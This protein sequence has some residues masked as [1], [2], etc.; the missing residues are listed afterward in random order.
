MIILP[1][2]VIKFLEK[3]RKN[4]F[5]IYIVGGAVRNLLLNKGVTNWD[6]TTDATPEQILKLFKDAF[7]NNTYGT[8]SIPVGD[9]IFEVTPFR[10]EG[11]YKDF[12]H[13]EKI[14]WAKTVEEDLSRRDF[15]I[16]AM[17]YDGKKIVDPYK[18]Q[19]DLKNKL[20]KAVGDPDKRFNED[21]LRLI[22][23][24]RFASQLG[25]FIDEKT[26][27]SIEKNSELIT[28]ISWERIRDEFLKILGSDHPSEGLLF[29]KNTG[30]LTFILPEVDICFTIPQKSPKRHHVYDVGTHLVM[31]LKHCPSKDAVT[32]F[33][34]LIHDTGKAQTFRRDDKTG[35]ITFYNH[36]VVGKKLAEQIADRFKLSNKEK[37]K[38][39]KLVEFHQFT[40]SEIQTDKAVRRFIRNVGKEYLN[41]IVDLRFGDRIGSGARPTS[42]RFDLFRKRLEKVQKQPFQ[43]KDLKINGNDVMKVLKIKPGPKVGEVLKKIFDKVVEKK[44]KNEREILLKEIKH[45]K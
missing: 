34:T 8:V 11:E 36:E 45:L 19:E 42:W 26:R 3:F 22:R 43:I 40:V 15:T 4:H 23:A 9:L 27:V 18:G 38:L 39:V 32:R 25:F 20:I 35:L 12:R 13:P 17:A 37:D 5:Q 10:K 31:S 14:T 24:I 44:L 29:L 2:P 21:S 7:Y 33:A 41:D 16:N 6:F 1:K 30:L 28:K